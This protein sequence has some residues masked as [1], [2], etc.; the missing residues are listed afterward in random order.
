MEE[1][2]QERKAREAEEKEKAERAKLI[3]EQFKDPKAEWEKDGA[4]MKEF[5]QKELRES[6]GEAKGGEAGPAAAPPHKETPRDG[7]K[8]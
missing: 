1:M 7:D 6:S 4:A 3:K 8:G 5:F 2:E